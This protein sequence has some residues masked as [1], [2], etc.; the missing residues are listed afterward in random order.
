MGNEEQ[1]MKKGLWGHVWMMRGNNVN[2][3]W[4][5]IFQVYCTIRYKFMRTKKRER[6][7]GLTDFSYFCD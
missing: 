5:D 3:A 2:V 6:N 1:K 7:D 4:I